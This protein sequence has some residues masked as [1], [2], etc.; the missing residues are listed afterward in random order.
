MKEKLLSELNLLRSNQ[1]QK[2]QKSE[3]FLQ[4]LNEALLTFE[5]QLSSGVEPEKSQHPLIFVFG[6]PRSGTTLT[7][8]VI[9][10]YLKV[11]YINN[12]SARFWKAPTVGVRLAKQFLGTESSVETSSNFGQTP[13]LG[14]VHDFGY[15]W[16]QWLRMDNVDSACE[17]DK[18]RELIPWEELVRTMVS[19][20]SEFESPLLMKNIL[21][22]HHFE[23]LNSHLGPIIWVNIRRNETDNALSI[24]N[25]REKFYGNR[26]TWWSCA[27][28]EYHELVDLPW[29]KQIA[30]QVHH[31]NRFYDSLHQLPLSE[32]IINFDYEDLC[33]S[34]EDL[35]TQIVGK[36]RDLFD[37]EI[38]LSEEPVSP[39]EMRDY[40]G[41]KNRGEIEEAL[42]SF[43]K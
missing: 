26:E 13:G 29:A 9:A 8:Q 17:V 3:N 12:L 19:L 10:R 27:P 24:M 35:L 28:P 40:G 39:L 42:K 43:I 20:K 32:R 1:F 25:A 4:E 41:H 11:G 38:L 22:A 18:E 30:G 14:N 15:F 36:S 5:G 37:S 6:C 16:R 21:G 2:D 31:L 34:P 33:R 7:T 23:A